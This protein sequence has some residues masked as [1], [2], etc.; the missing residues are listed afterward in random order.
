MAA[1]HHDAFVSIRPGA[2]GQ[3]LFEGLAADH[4][5]VYAGEE[6]SEAVWFAAVFRQEVEIVVQTGDEAVETGADKDGYFHRST[7]YSVTAGLAPVRSIRPADR[8]W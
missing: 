3:N 6:F 1:Q 2:E 5:R 8:P 4:Q 7:G